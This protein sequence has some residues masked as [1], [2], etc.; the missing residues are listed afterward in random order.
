[1]EAP[2]NLEFWN[3]AAGTKQFTHPLDP[4]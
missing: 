2:N 4:D 1:M 3:R